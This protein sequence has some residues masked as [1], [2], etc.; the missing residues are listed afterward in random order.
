MRKLEDKKLDEIGRAVVKASVLSTREIEEIAGDAM[1]FDS[2]R[3]RIAAET[4]K[5][6]RSWVRPTVATVS[7]IGILLAAIVAFSVLK[8][9]P[10]VDI[11]DRVISMPAT[12][13][14]NRFK[15]PDRIVSE[16][17]L[18]SPVTPV[19]TERVLQRSVG[20]KVDRPRIRTTQE[21]RS[22]NEFYAL[23]Y[24]GDPNE[25]ERG[26]RIVRVD[27]PRTVL[28]AMGVDIPLENEV[29][30]VKADLLIGSDGVTRAIRVVK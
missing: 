22:D 12:P 1:L 2:V 30:T 8:P 9:S 23:S 26:G 16:Y 10:V 24:A 21:N 7:A 5:T 3:N 13:P 14:V 29:E 18:P 6:T 20:T 25:T 15:E 27:L 11:A 19:R 17:R 28:F 4:S